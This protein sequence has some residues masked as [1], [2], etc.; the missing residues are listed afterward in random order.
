MHKDRC[1]PA[2]NRL[3]ASVPYASRPHSSKMSAMLSGSS[4]MP[5]RLMVKYVGSK[6][7]VTCLR[8]AVFQCLPSGNSG[9]VS[10]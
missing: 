3:D 10:T 9:A 2:L 8:G 6:P 7:A 1:L 4:C 5:P